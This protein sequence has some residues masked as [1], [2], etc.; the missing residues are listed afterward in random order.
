ML[1][2]FDKF[3]THSPADP[4][5]YGV[6]YFLKGQDNLWIRIFVGPNILRKES[7]SLELLRKVRGGPRL[8]LEIIYLRRLFKTLRQ[9]FRRSPWRMRKLEKRRWIKTLSRFWVWIFF[10]VWKVKLMMTTAF[11]YLIN[12]VCLIPPPLVAM[13]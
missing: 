9:I 5:A 10:Q 8:L 13:Y 4:P 11:L 2:A 12:L 7:C 6:T 3:P 1:T